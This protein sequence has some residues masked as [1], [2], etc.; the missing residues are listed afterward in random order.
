MTKTVTSPYDVAEHLRAPE[1]MAA[2]LEACMEEANGDAAFIAKALGDIARAKGMS[3]V[4]CDAGL[5]REGLYRAL[6]GERNPTLDTVLRVIGALGLKLR[7]EAAVPS[8]NSIRKKCRPFSKMVNSVDL[9]SIALNP[10]GSI[11]WKGQH[12]DGPGSGG[13]YPPQA[14]ED[15]RRRHTQHPPRPPPSLQRLP[16]PGP[17]PSH[18]SQAQAGITDPFALP[19][20][21]HKRR[22][23]PARAPLAQNR[24]KQA[25]T[26]NG[27]DNHQPESPAS[28]KSANRK[29]RDPTS[30]SKNPTLEP[31]VTNPG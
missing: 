18:G 5:S 16:V 9:R 28:L 13:H 8:I 1:E 11:K 25:K 31:F 30:A 15:R 7:A 10:S 4:A 19:T 22:R 20:Q 27:T 21:T 14:P 23:L 3:Q 24:P 12:H 29:P 17:G 6:S 26:G 2:Y